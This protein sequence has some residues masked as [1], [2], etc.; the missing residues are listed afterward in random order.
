MMHTEREY[1]EAMFSLAAECGK[2][3]EYLEALQCIRTLLREN[4]LYIEFLSSPAGPLSERC[5]AIDEAFGSYDEHICSFLKILCGNSRVRNVCECIDEFE[6][7]TLA[8]KSKVSCTVYSVV[9]L[10][11]E[12]K[13]KLCKKLEKTT[14]KS[15]DVTYLTDKSLLGGLRIVLEDKTYDGSIK[16]RLGEVKD[17]IIG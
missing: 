10:D 2:S 12:Q 5:K 4:P 11:D 9:E 16:H 17:V 15:V 3:E 8:A 6:K 1:A 13:Q 7:L 14:G